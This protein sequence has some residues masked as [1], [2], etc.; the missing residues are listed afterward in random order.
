MTDKPRKASRAWIGWGLVAAL[1]LYP[2]SVVPAIAT[3]R[4]L[5][6]YHVISLNGRTRH[7]LAFAYAPILAWSHDHP[8]V[9][10]AMRKAI[11]AICP[12]PDL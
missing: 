3:Y 2:V 10:D 4:C 1:V 7:A 8:R 5:V 11:R 12:R 6:A 9:H